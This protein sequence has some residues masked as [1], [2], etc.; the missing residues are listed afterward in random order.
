MMVLVWMPPTKTECLLFCQHAFFFAVV[1][2]VNLRAF[3]M[4]GRFSAIDVYPQPFPGHCLKKY[5]I[6]LHTSDLDFPASLFS[7]SLSLWTSQAIVEVVC[8]CPQASNSHAGWL[9]CS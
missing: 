6:L 4:L 7:C 5:T 3:H 8:I 1:L 2:A 9:S